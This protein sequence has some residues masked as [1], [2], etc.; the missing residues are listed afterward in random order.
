MPRRPL[1]S[2]WAASA[3]ARDCAIFQ[4]PY[5][6]EGMRREAWSITDYRILSLLHDG[7]SSFVY[8]AVCLYSSIAVALKVF[9]LGAM[10]R[11][12]QEIAFCEV[13][14]HRRVSN[15][16]NIIALHAAFCYNGFLV[17]VQEYAGGG[18][19]HDVLALV[20]GRMSEQAAARVVLQPLLRALQHLH[21]CGVVHRDVNP[22]NVLFTRRWDLRLADFGL[23]APIDAQGAAYSLWG[24][25]APEVR[26]GGAYTAAADVWSTGML[27][28]KVMVGLTPLLLP[29]CAEPAFPR[30]V[31]S[32]GRA[33]VTAALR[34]DPDERPSAQDLGHHT[35]RIL[36]GDHIPRTKVPQTKKSRMAAHL[37]LCP[38]P[39]SI[40]CSQDEEGL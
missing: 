1:E 5:M 25:M 33:V 18:T 35:I 10:S 15:H 4:A 14:V 20:G 2:F 16:P 24:Y 17:L 32:L 34:D 37:A 9:D 30:F 7:H 38:S 39:C 29:G 31:G 13:D 40:R 6:P 19:L 27:A 8:K 26:R 36:M 3:G 12:Q 22:D 28:Y 11:A 23:A 21:S